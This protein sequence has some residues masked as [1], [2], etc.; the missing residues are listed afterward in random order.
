MQELLF[1]TSDI[2]SSHNSA[3]LQCEIKIYGANFAVFVTNLSKIARALSSKE[4][5]EN[6]QEF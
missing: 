5:Q 1:A 2:L 3:M 4:S 6:F